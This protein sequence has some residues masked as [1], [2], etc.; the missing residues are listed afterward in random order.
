MSVVTRGFAG[1]GRSDPK[2]PPGQYLT[3][4]F[5]VLSAGPTPRVDTST[6]EF[7]IITE[8]GERRS[9]S[10]SDMMALPADEPTV[11]LHCVTKWSKLHTGW[12]GV[13]L[14]VLFADVESSADYALVHAY[15]GYTT[16]LPI[17][18]LMDGQA[19]IAYSYDGSPLP[20]EH[21]RAGSAARTA[22]VF[23][24][25]RQVGSGDPDDAG[26][27]PRILG[28]RRLSQL[29]RPMAR[30][31][32][33]RRLTW[34]PATVLEVREETASARTLV[35]G[36]P[37][38]P[39]HLAGQHLDVR[40][41]A[42]NGYTAQRS[43][44]IASAGMPVDAPLEITVQRVVD[45]EVSP[46]LVDNAVMGDQVE[47]RG[48]VGGYF[49]WQPED[50]RAVLAI[51]GGSGVVPLMAMART[52]AVSSA[53]VPFRLIYS[54]RGPDDVIYANDLAVI[55]GIDVQFIYTRHRHRPGGRMRAAVSIRYA[56]PSLL[57]QRPNHHTSSCVVR[58]DSSSRSPTRWWTWDTTRAE[59][60]PSASDPPEDDMTSL[61]G[62]VLAGAFAELFGS[63]MTEA[64]GRCHGCGRVGPVGEAVVY[65][66]SAGL[67]ARC[68]GC[69]AVLMTVVRADDR[70]YLSLR[71]LSFLEVRV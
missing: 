32:V 11:D 42:E 36:V 37:D 7:Q 15:G 4:D 6:W 65:P 69:D 16:N 28:D 26:G 40:L 34:Q 9:W 50:D 19:W 10:W 62:N 68:P 5:P 30:A 70:A 45:G 24:E 59:S 61:D 57:I 60:R 29:R 3:E 55:A 31:A 13:S 58:P 51:G 71:G 21:G 39:G 1:R 49:T 47:I 67:V 12:R 63:D 35:L 44:S 46:Y 14:D 8:T 18:D 64:R 43:Y 17:A 33:L 25:E 52:H 27:H 53:T 56:W 41:T 22:S 2:L 23:V 38:W 66:Q 20:A 48:P 54:V